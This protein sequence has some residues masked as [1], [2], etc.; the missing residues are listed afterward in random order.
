MSDHI[1]KTIRDL[2]KN[3]K[4]SWEGDVYLFGTFSKKVQDANED[5]SLA[6]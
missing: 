2:F 4:H 6:I 5:Y 3:G 1:Q